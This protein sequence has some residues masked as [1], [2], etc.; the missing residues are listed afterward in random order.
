MS[1]RRIPSCGS[2]VLSLLALGALGLIGACEGGN[3]L[4][5]SGAEN[6]AVDAAITQLAAGEEVIDFEALATGAI[7]D[8]VHSSS[9]VGPVVVKGLNPAL[10]AAVNAAV[11]FDSASPP[12][13]DFD[14]GTPN[15][16]FGGPGI[17]TGG[18]A[19]SPHENNTAQG[20]IAIVATNVNDG[21]G[22]M[23]VDVP[24]DADVAGSAIEFNFAALGTVTVKRMLIIDIEQDEEAAT[25]DLFDGSDNLLQDFALPQVGNNGVA[26]ASLG[27]TSG[28]VRMLVTLNGS[29]AIDD[30]VFEVDDVCGDGNLDP[31]EECDDGNDVD[32][33]ACRNDCTL[34]SC[35][36]GIV[37]AGEEC[38]DG[39]EVDDDACRNDC[40]LPSCGD[41]IVDDG[42]E[43]DDGND[44]NVDCCRNDCTLPFCGDGIVDARKNCDDDDGDHH[45]HGDDCDDD[46]D[47]DDDD[48]D[49]DCDDDD[50]D[51]GGHGDDDCDDDDDDDGDDDD[52]DEG[53]D[54]DDDDKDRDRY[55]GSHDQKDCDD[56]DDDKDRRRGEECDDGND[57]NTDGCRNDCTLPF[58]GDGIVDPGEEC[59]DGNN[60]DCDGC[61]D[62]CQV[63]GSQGCTLGYWKN[64]LDSWA[65]TGYAPSD[66]LGSVFDIPGSFSS[67][68]DDSL[69]DALMY[70]GGPGTIDKA[71]LLLK[72]AVA[73]LLSAA[74]PGVAYGIADPQDV[75]DAVNDALA[76]MN[77]GAIESLQSEL[78]GLNNAG[79]PLN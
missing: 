52:D 68:A 29:G 43:C 57:I 41:G 13:L 31:G 45:G 33:D 62:D 58:C 44:N 17:G 61:S 9:G 15:E 36:D 48:D 26:T 53:D 5:S 67:L 21:N 34:P 70:S 59:D 16:D 8:E 42:E 64:H 10:G 72:Q 39:N 4:L 40:T 54:D 25:V 20:K 3:A 50:K 56:D 23:L 11:V 19:G 75:V 73:A 35:G 69:L 28:V 49:D 37:D 66:T 7:I 22:D 46:H 30:I 1:L 76:T 78:D 14:L 27:P 51:R 79:C 55:K 77:K 63:E 71:R 24:N 12:G 65:A 47:G 18:E 2:P 32:D 74:H 38:D 60:K 6:S